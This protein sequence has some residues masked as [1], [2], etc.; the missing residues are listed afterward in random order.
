MGQNNWFLPPPPIFGNILL[1]YNLPYNLI[2]KFPRIWVGLMVLLTEI[3]KIILGKLEKKLTLIIF[4]L[5]ST[6]KFSCKKDI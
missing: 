2:I 3:V 4:K 1:V 5:I 6:F